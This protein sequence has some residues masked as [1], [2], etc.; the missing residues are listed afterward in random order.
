MQ[1]Y[2]CSPKNRVALI[3]ELFGECSHQEQL[4]L[5]RDLADNLKRDFFKLLP[6]ELA[7]HVLSYLPPT[8]VLGS[9]IRVSAS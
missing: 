5:L 2:P 1:S 3:R 4:Q 7:E 6:L 9:C 8:C